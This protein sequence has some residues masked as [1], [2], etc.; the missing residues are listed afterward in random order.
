MLPEP[1]I[2]PT[3]F[4]GPNTTI[5]GDVH[6]GP[7]VVILPGVVI[8]AEMEPVFIGPESNVQDNSVFHVDD[9]YPVTLGRRV[10]IGHSATIPLRAIGPNPASTNRR[11]PGISRAP[12]EKRTGGIPTDLYQQTEDV[13]NLFAGV[14]QAPPRFEASAGHAFMDAAAMPMRPL[15]SRLE[16][17]GFPCAANGR[18]R[19]RH[20]CR[21]PRRGPPGPVL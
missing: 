8:R 7:S 3:A 1:T 18:R 10:T 15:L 2:D 13:P 14:R 5:W 4:I 11:A 17:R 12:A 19:S 20:S 21:S 6:L 9:G 16:N